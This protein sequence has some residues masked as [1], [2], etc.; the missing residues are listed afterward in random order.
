M[1]VWQRL[2]QGGTKDGLD[3][4]PIPSRLVTEEDLQPLY[5]AM[6][7][8]EASSAGVKRKGEQSS[9]DT[10][11]YG[12]GKRARE[13]RSYN[14]QWTEEEFEKLCQGD[15]PES[16]QPS[17]V[18][19]GLCLMK[20]QNDP[21]SSDTKSSDTVAPPKELPTLAN[22]SNQLVQPDESSQPLK[23]LP[24]VKRGRGR[25]KRGAVNVTSPVLVP[26]APSTLGNKLELEPQKEVFAAIVDAPSAGGL[27][28]TS[29]ITQHTTVVGP[30]SLPLAGPLVKPRARGRK[31][32]PGEKPRGRA[33][34]Q[35]PVS[36]ITGAEV[37]NTSVLQTGIDVSANKSAAVPT[38]KVG[39]GVPNVSPLACQVNSISESQKVVEPGSAR[40]SS[41][42]QS[43]ETVMS[44]SPV[45]LDNKLI[46]KEIPV[47][48]KSAPVETKPVTTD[49]ACSLQPKNTVG[50]SPLISTKVSQDLVE[51]KTGIASSDT[52]SIGE[53]RSSEKNYATS[54]GNQK[55]LPSTDTKLN[56]NN[57][58]TDK[59]D[60]LYFQSLQTR[61]LGAEINCDVKSPARQ[62]EVSVQSI[63][64]TEPISVQRHE[65]QKSTASLQNS[66]TLAVPGNDAL[67]SVP[68]IISIGDK[69]THAE[70]AVLAGHVETSPVPVVTQ[71]AP[72]TRASVTR[73]KAAARE[74]RN[75]GTSTAACER[76]ARLAGLKQAE[77]SKKV[78]AKGKTAKAVAIEEKEGSGDPNKGFVL[79]DAGGSLED[80]RPKVLAPGSVPI[81]LE[82]STGNLLVP[83]I[84][85]RQLNL[86][87]AGEKAYA[88][89]TGRPLQNLK[90]SIP[91]VVGS[92]PTKIEAGN[93][94]AQNSLTQLVAIEAGNC[95]GQ[96]SLTQ[97]V[98]VKPN[99]TAD[100]NEY[101]LD[102]C[103]TLPETG[104]HHTPDLL[105]PMVPPLHEVSV[106]AELT[107]GEPINFSEG[108][109]T[110][111]N[112]MLA[113]SE[114]KSV[115]TTT[116]V[117]KVS[118]GNTVE[119]SFT[120]QTGE[121]CRTG[122]SS[123]G[124][125][126]PLVQSK[127][128]FG[129]VLTCVPKKLF[130]ETAPIDACQG[131]T[132]TAT[133]LKEDVGNADLTRSEA[134]LA[135]SNNHD[136]TGQVVEKTVKVL[137]EVSVSEPTEGNSSEIIIAKQFVPEANPG[138][139]VN[140]ADLPSAPSQ[141]ESSAQ[142]ATENAAE[143]QKKKF[144]TDG[145]SVEGSTLICRVSNDAEECDKARS[146]DTL[147]N[148]RNSDNV[149][150]ASTTRSMADSSYPIEL[151]DIPVNVS[152]MD[153]APKTSPTAQ[154]VGSCSDIVKPSDIIPN[155]VDTPV[156]ISAERADKC[157]EASDSDVPNVSSVLVELGGDFCRISEKPVPDSLS[158]EIS[159]ITTGL[160]LSTCTTSKSVDITENSAEPRT[161]DSH[162]S[163]PE[164]ARTDCRVRHF[165]S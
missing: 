145:M 92:S 49:R 42:S 90:D 45:P 18:P 130:T 20:D 141:A 29:A 46:E 165:D 43:V 1:A 125:E 21:K 5:K 128:T 30:A 103:G 51:K 22:D 6:T 164:S 62:A 136:L 108:N 97:L 159:G 107:V 58:P 12:R 126:P 31:A 106:T 153:D 122:D 60:D 9:L 23:Q 139:L 15:S 71:R 146:S 134:S 98:T 68:A 104:K 101:S 16:S 87:A 55:V 111:S 39:S 119:L 121:H 133:T 112:S 65:E 66:S 132:C 143:E 142:E 7:M 96:T 137:S 155:S 24:P 48:D 63:K 135:N 140:N 163:V 17:E 105:R 152:D 37:N 2:I 117:D 74:T 32:T 158:K 144:A 91:I 79:S 80:T 70:L 88:D 160:D 41:F 129:S 72:E 57:K 124:E 89:Q 35:N 27:N 38:D 73:K 154:V 28:P 69:A 115:Q 25:P 26:P 33:R 52:V 44:I 75:R 147:V 11:H 131:A 118:E 67:F 109:I 56:A 116:M 157:T 99:P 34:K 162:V 50:P 113:Y 100:R 13:V 76:R 149:C 138:V 8:Y 110:C 151:S 114:T 54:Q 120:Q 4:V 102:K 36:S 150:G 84:S 123:S 83:S 10:Q 61:L 95:E 161:D 47:Y 19:E 81:Q 93:N 40:A 77:G 156:V 59:Q 78:E 148:D 94:M 86:S 82:K 85:D 3:S 64:E 127:K 14:D 53:Q